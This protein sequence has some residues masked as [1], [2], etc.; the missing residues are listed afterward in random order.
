MRHFAQAGDKEFFQRD[1]SF[2]WFCHCASLLDHSIRPIQHRLRNRE[3]DLLRGLE[4]DHQL[5]LRRLLHRQVSRLGTLEDSVP[6]SSCYHDDINLKTH[7]LGRKLRI[8]ILLPPPNIGTRW[9]CSVLLC[10]Q[11]RAEPAELPRH[12][13]TQ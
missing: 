4:I 7:Q 11:A 13:W 5:K 10:S 12:G 1:R 9:R 8:P 3:A 6:C 2:I